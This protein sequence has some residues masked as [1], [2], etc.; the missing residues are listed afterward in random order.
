MINHIVIGHLKAIWS[1]DAT[2][3]LRNRIFSRR[4]QSKEKKTLIVIWCSFWD[5]I[6]KPRKKKRK[7]EKMPISQYKHFIPILEINRL[8]VGVRAWHNVIEIVRMTEKPTKT[9]HTQAQYN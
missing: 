5:A 6:E 9:T 7:T 3:I 1:R 8:N 4:D 2:N